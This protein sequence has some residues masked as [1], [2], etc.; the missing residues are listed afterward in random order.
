MRLLAYIFLLLWCLAWTVGCSKPVQ[1]ASGVKMLLVGEIETDKEGHSTE[2]NSI[3][4]K[5]KVEAE[6]DKIWHVYIISPFDRKIVMKSTAKG[7][8]TSS[9][10]RLTP[11]ILSDGQS[12]KFVVDGKTYYTREMPSEDGTFGSSAQYIYWVDEKGRNHRHFLLDGQII[13][14]VDQKMTTSELLGE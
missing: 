5:I 8:I 10:K 3:A 12:M 13:H 4:N 14:V 2:Q 6:A 11:K 7:K 1:S 9:G